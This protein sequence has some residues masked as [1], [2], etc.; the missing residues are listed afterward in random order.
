MIS[1]EVNFGFSMPLVKVSHMTVEFPKFSKVGF[2]I[3][4]LQVHASH[5]WQIGSSRFCG[6]WLACLMCPLTYCL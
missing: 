3:N 2:R 1:P 4:F 6:L 5:L